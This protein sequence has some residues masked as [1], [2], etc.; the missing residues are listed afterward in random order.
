MPDYYSPSASVGADT[1]TTANI[2][3]CTL[4]NGITNIQ[5]LVVKCGAQYVGQTTHYRQITHS[6]TSKGMCTSDSSDCS[7]DI[8]C[9]VS[10]NSRLII[11]VKRIN[12]DSSG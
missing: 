5:H 3:R 11:T 7:P 2:Q 1:T 10:V 12:V 9:I 4:I 6:T 8:S